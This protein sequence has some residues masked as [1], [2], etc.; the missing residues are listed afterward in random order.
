M[1]AFEVTT[2]KV[3]ANY[4]SLKLAIAM[5]AHELIIETEWAKLLEKEN[6]NLDAKLCS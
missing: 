1:H 3:E 2:I 5:D 6:A 4:K